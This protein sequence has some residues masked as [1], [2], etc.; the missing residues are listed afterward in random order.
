LL[1]STKTKAFG[2]YPL[3]RGP[4]WAEK[5]NRTVACKAQ[6]VA[7]YEEPNPIGFSLPDDTKGSVR[8]ASNKDGEMT[9]G[10]GRLWRVGLKSMFAA[11]KTEPELAMKLAGCTKISDISRR[12]GT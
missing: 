11:W 12:L 2:Y 3:G 5:L 6:I 9:I 7:Q 8:L 10:D 1:R 4:K